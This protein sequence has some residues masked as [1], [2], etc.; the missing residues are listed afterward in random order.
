MVIIEE[1]YQTTTTIE[2]LLGLTKKRSIASVIIMYTY[3]ATTFSET[4]IDLKEKI[5][6]SSI[7]VGVNQ[8]VGLR[9]KN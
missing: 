3:V 6:I 5:V 4:T 8:S 2:L 1:H 9:A 7:Y